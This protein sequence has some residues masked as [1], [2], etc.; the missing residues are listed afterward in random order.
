MAR[1]LE[2]RVDDWIGNGDGPF[3]VEREVAEFCRAA[4]QDG[5]TY[6]ADAVQP[7][8]TA[9]IEAAHAD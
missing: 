2:Q 7:I 4:E 3:D 8:M 6:D 1:S 9:R 5:E